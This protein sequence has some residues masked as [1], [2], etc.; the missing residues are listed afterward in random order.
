MTKFRILD[1][2]GSRVLVNV[3]YYDHDGKTP[4]HEAAIGGHYSLVKAI[5]ER[6]E[7]NVEA[8]DYEVRIP[9]RILKPC[10]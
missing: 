4:L 8:R 5:L 7:V 2:F 6:E 1:K 3:T 9:L 10:K